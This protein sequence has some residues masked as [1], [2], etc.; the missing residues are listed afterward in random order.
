MK[1]M[2]CIYLEKVDFVKFV[3]GFVPRRALVTGV[4]FKA[5]SFGKWVVN[6]ACFFGGVGI[7]LLMRFFSI[8]L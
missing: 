7:G 8:I 6:C 4:S 2:T 3:R 1:E 5:V